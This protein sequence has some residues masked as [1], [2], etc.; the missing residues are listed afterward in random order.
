M[1]ASMNEVIARLRQGRGGGGIVD[2]VPRASA[3]PMEA[4]RLF[5]LADAVDIY[6][7]VSYA[8]ARAVLAAVLHKDMAYGCEILPHAQA[9]QLASDFLNQF[10]LDCS[11]F[12]TNGEYGLPRTQPNVGPGWMSATEA[13]FDTGVLILCADVT[14]C[15]WFMDED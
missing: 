11:R 6:H 15:A 10:Q 1:A 13:T 14:G 5:G 8:E 4:A 12:Y 7:E 3:S 2:V 9:E